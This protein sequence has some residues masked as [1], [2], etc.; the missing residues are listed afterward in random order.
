MKRKGEYLWIYFE[1]K[2]FW[3]VP[4]R[5][6]ANNLDGIHPEAVRAYHKSHIS[7]T[8][9]IAVVGVAFEDILYNGVRAINL[10]FRYISRFQS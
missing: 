4:L 3:G 6:T 9:G 8:T 7:K 1:R 2:W 5:K 10:L